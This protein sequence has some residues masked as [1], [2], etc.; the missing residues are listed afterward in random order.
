MRDGSRNSARGEEN[1]ARGESPEGDG[2]T[3][4]QIKLSARRPR[5]IRRSWILERETGY[6]ARGTKHRVEVSFR[7]A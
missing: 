4:P 6:V 3:P 1:G 5:Q 7:L 2:G